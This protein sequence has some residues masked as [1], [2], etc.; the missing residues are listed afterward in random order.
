MDRN[1]FNS[2]FSPSKRGINAIH[3]KQP[4]NP[5]CSAIK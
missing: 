4:M 5:N 3:E 1:N 2:T